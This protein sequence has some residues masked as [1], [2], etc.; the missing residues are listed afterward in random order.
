M[1]KVDSPSAKVVHLSIANKRQE[2]FQKF[3]VYN[4]GKYHFITYANIVYFEATSNYTIIH[5]SNQEKMVISKTLKS[6]EASIP[7]HRFF[8]IHSKYVINLEHIEQLQK[9]SSGAIINV[10]DTSLPISRRKFPH[11][12]T[13]LGI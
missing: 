9:N 3:P 5:L 4:N 10:K 6:I 13:I 1:P 8:R 7:D 12:K 11:L 2:N